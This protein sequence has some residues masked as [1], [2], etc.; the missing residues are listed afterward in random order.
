[1]MTGIPKLGKHISVSGVVDKFKVSG[2]IARMLL[3]ELHKNGT[4]L[5]GEKHGKQCLFYPAA[6]AV[7]KVA[8]ATDKEAGKKAGKKK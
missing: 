3:S 7:E 6:V 2:S 5:T 1:M 4:L 8:V